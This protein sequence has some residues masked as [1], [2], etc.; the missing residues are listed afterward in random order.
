MG[1][2]NKTQ[3][4]KCLERK[5]IYTN[6]KDHRNTLISQRSKIRRKLIMTKTFKFVKEKIK[7]L[8]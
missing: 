7:L 5:K 3:K 8:N 1:K 6:P 4:L 2:S